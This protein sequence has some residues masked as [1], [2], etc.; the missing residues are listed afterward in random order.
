VAPER[1]GV[2]SIDGAPA[3]GLASGLIPVEP[4]VALSGSD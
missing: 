1:R 3:A 2:R 4:A